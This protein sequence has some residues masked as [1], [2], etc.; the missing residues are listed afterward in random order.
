MKIKTLILSSLLLLLAV[1]AQ[2]EQ[3]VILRTHAFGME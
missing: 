1:A 2:A 3:E